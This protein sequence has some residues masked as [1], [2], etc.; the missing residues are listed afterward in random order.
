MQHHIDIVRSEHT[1]ADLVYGPFSCICKAR[2]IR[3][4]AGGGYAAW[5]RWSAQH[6]RDCERTDGAANMLHQFPFHSLPIGSCL[7]GQ[8][9]EC[10]HGSA[11]HIMVDPVSILKGPVSAAGDDQS[12]VYEKHTWI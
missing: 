8:S 1:S 12:T 10:V 2:I 6:L 9:D 3:Q 11:F 7:A 5:R 4:E